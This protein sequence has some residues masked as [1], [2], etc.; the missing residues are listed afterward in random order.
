LNKFPQQQIKKP[1]NLKKYSPWKL[2]N[3][4]ELKKFQSSRHSSTKN[5]SLSTVQPLENSKAQLSVPK[6]KSKLIILELPSFSIICASL[7]SSTEVTLNSIP[8]KKMENVS[9]LNKSIS[10]IVC[11]LADYDGYLEDLGLKLD[12]RDEIV[13][14]NE[15]DYQNT[16]VVE[17]TSILADFSSREPS[18]PL[19]EKQEMLDIM[20]IEN[21]AAEPTIMS[22][23]PVSV[24]SS[25]VLFNLK[26][27]WKSK[28][29]SGKYV[30]CV[31]KFG[32]NATVQVLYR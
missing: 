24:T 18:F 13:P 28:Q 21:I 16:E 29:V 7:A 6:I 31:I 30:Y 8:P 3:G 11:K 32:W 14:L 4:K 1:N 26:M 2:N 22:F 5:V 20:N 19:N 15:F 9:K 27:L 17:I 10:D 23:V 12:D 25:I